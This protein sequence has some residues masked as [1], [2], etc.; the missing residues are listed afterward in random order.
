MKMMNDERK[1][2][3]WFVNDGR[4]VQ[5]WNAI[6]MLNSIYFGFRPEPRLETWP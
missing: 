6:E 5:K 2:P 1:Q 3:I 4:S